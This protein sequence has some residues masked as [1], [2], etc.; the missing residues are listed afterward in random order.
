MATHAIRS[1]TIHSYEE[2]SPKSARERH[3]DLY[4]ESGVGVKSCQFLTW[5]KQRRTDGRIHGK[6]GHRGFEDT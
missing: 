2:K 5:N 6:A 3:K 4:E 1:C